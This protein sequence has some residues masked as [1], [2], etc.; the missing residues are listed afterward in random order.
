MAATLTA[1]GELTFISFPI[2][3]AETDADGNVLVYGKASDGALDSDEQIIDPDFAAKAIR[4]WLNDG[5]NVRVQ[6][7]AQRDP[8]GVGVDMDVDGDGGTWVKSK[9]IEPIAQKLVLGGA[10]RAYSVG[11]ARPQIVRD[12]RARG[13]LIKGGQV[14]EIS[15]VDRP[16]NKNCAIQLVKAAKDGSPELSGEITG[17]DEFIQKMISTGVLTKDSIHDH[18]IPGTPDTFRHGWLKIGGDAIPNDHPTADRMSA[19]ALRAHM[20]SYHSGLPGIGRRTGKKKSGKDELVAMHEEMHRAQEEAVTNHQLRPVTRDGVLVDWGL[21][22]THGMG[23]V[24]KPDYTRKGAGVTAAV[25]EKMV[26]LELPEDVSVAVTP[27]DLARIIGKRKSGNVGE[28]THPGGVDRATLPS[29]AFAGRN[30]SFPITSPG[31]VSDA[32][33]SVGRAGDDNYST[34]QLQA[35]IKRIAH[36]KGPEFVAALPDTAKTADEAEVLK[37]GG[38]CTTCHGGGKIRDGHM[39]CPDCSG[40]G[41]VNGVA[42]RSDDSDADDSAEKAESTA[43]AG[44][45]VEKGEKETKIVV[46]GSGD[47]DHDGDGLFDADGDGDGAVARRVSDDSAEKAFKPAGKKC[48]TCRGA[49]KIMGGNRKCPDCGGSGTRVRKSVAAEALKGKV[50]C[51]KCGG[52]MKGKSRFCPGC[53]APAGGSVGETPD[54]TGVKKSE[55]AEVSAELIE[56]SESP[57]EAASARGMHTEEAPAHREPDGAAVE[58]LEDDAHMQDDDH[59]APGPLEAPALKSESG[60]LALARIVKSGVPMTM[61]VLH[62]MTCAAFS[63]EM[64]VKCYPDR[65]LAAEINE[66]EW[67]VKSLDMATS[68]PYHEAARAAQLGHHASTLKHA[69]PA[70]VWEAHEELHKAFGDANPGPGTA[71]TPAACQPGQFQRPYISAG[72]A[73]PSPA[74]GS[75]NQTPI[76]S[77]EIEA[78]QFKRP[79]LSDGHAAMSP[80]SGTPNGV[81]SASAAVSKAISDVVAA[82]AGRT[83]YSHAG[84]ETTRTAMQAIHDHIQQTF[85]DIC[86]MHGEGAK[87][88][89]DAAPETMKMPAV[90][91][92]LT[93][94]EQVTGELV[95]K[96][97]ELTAAAPDVITE[98]LTELQ[99]TVRRQAKL[100]KK[101]A[102]TL[103]QLS[104]QPDPAVFAYRGAALAAPIQKM[105]TS[106]PA[107]PTMAESAERIQAMRLMELEHDWRTTPYPA[108]REAAWREILKIRGIS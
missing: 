80:G 66:V 6:H 99:A 37:I 3:K 51:G 31:D 16:A 4:D 44:D 23:A 79:F 70:D 8:A 25:A 19:G 90:P 78:A 56:K 15:L 83:F 107:A 93:K 32:W 34:E 105:Q 14:V 103:S 57:A 43:T 60:A 62:D 101:Q 96:S 46:E 1:D 50:T 69:V 12:G 61:G 52:A 30:R 72:H 88:E 94:G 73:A 55:S 58:A 49:G 38:T 11:I 100:L 18:H 36:E 67:Q 40:T 39:K 68:L 75:P 41:N 104:A 54:K 33:Q 102:K 92:Q 87:K 82:K 63:P 28:D 77:G 64:I 59:E 76:T 106:A 84:R 85:P 98:Q 35:N 48:K 22:H 2:A 26:T 7:N 24:P 27:A 20:D 10:L 47:A 9:I 81:P 91:R 65:S 74:Y 95:T 21:A 97:V 5:A 108:Q 42:D 89:P 17:N 71:P 53:G 86:P 45:P 13:G 29:S